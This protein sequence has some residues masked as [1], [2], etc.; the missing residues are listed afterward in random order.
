[1]DADMKKIKDM[2]DPVLE[3]NKGRLKITGY[4][5]FPKSSNGGSKQS[6]KS[7]SVHVHLSIL[8]P[9]VKNEADK[10]LF[11]LECKV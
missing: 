9:C 11:L 8:K 7:L 4:Q 5:R 3:K 10:P 1:M 2:L 6:Q